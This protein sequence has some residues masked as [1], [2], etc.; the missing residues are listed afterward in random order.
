MKKHVFTMAAALALGTALPLAA[1]TKGV[2]DDSVIIGGAHD[3]SG[4]FAPF[5][6]PAV[7]G[8][9]HYFHQVNAA[10]GVHGRKIEYVVE[11]HGYQ[12]PKAMQA[13]NKL[14][15]RNGV[16]STMLNLGTPHNIAM[17]KMMDPKG[18]PN[19]SPLSAA[20]QM[21]EPLSPTKFAGTPAY[22]DQVTAQLGYLIEE[23]GRDGFCA[24]ILP[25]DFGEEIRE[26]MHEELEAR[27]LP[28][29]AESSHKPDEKDFAGALGK[30]HKEGCKTIGLAL[31]VSQAITAVVTADK[32]GLKDMSFFFTSAGFL[33][34]TAGALGQQG[35]TLTVYAGAGYPDVTQRMDVPEVRAWADDFTAK[36]GDKPE[37]AAMLG[38]S[39]ALTVV[40]ALEAAGP[41]LTHE[42][43]IKG[44]ESLNY[45]D[46]VGGFHVDYGPEDHVG[47]ED[48][49]ISEVAGGKWDLIGTVEGD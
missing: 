42:S 26:G 29:L 7:K 14:I 13:A 28:F 45:F 27:G 19:T 33:P 41:D 35:V 40:K 31:G 32:M 23:E 44:M 2:T 38:Y 12:I 36:T 9:Q 6:V 4:I 1:D 46:T 17:F 30:L 25:T 8:A 39:A 3:L 43:F 10:G 24:M 18:I 47:G 22:Y 20:R 34:V 16:F 15:N 5:S 21:A 11:D 37:I 49:F 48:I